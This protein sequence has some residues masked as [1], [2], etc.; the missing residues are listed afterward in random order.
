M[1]HGRAERDTMTNER[2][3]E[4]RAERRPQPD[5]RET[6]IMLTCPC[7]AYAGVGSVAESFELTFCPSH[8]EVTR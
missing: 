8:D 5:R 6:V 2:T 7:G 3:S 4:R 1:A